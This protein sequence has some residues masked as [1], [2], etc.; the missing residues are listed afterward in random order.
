LS[1]LRKNGKPNAARMDH[2]LHGA[3][4]SIFLGNPVPL[5]PVAQGA[6]LPSLIKRGTRRHGIQG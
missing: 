6:R 4:P 1:R 2:S 5:A 3:T